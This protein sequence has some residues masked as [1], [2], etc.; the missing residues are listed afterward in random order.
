MNGSL[1]FI[2]TAVL[3]SAGANVMLRRGMGTMGGAGG[4]GA[5]LR[6]ALGS[7]WVWL[8]SLGFFAAMGSW[9]L[10]LSRAEISLV[11]PMFSGGTTLC[12]ILASVLLLK[13]KINLP[14]VIGALL[15]VSGIFVAYAS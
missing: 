4:F 6:H 7:L 8:G 5:T 9:L 1:P 12:V 14:R 3:L 13:E 2:V 11:Y 15:M 10:V